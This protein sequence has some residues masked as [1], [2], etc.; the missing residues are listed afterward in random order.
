MGIGTWMKGALAGALALAGVAA[1][2]PAGAQ[3][4]DEITDLIVGRGS[5]I[6]AFP[7]FGLELEDYDT[8]FA[9]K[10]DLLLKIRDS[11]H[12]RWSGRHR[13]RPGCWPSRAP[14]WRGAA[15]LAVTWKALWCAD[16]HSPRRCR[17]SSSR[18]RRR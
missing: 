10:L 9:E 11:E 5:F 7:L 6:E 3:T 8:L 4:V 17:G 1:A 16:I 12:V 2:A 18:S 15:G 13:P 14:S